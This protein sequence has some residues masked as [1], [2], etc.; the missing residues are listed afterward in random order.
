MSDETKPITTSELAAQIR[1]DTGPLPTAVGPVVAAPMPS[2]EGQNADVLQYIME[3]VRAIAEDLAEHKAETKANFAAMGKKQDAT[4]KDVLEIKTGVNIG[5]WVA[6]GV[7]SV[8][9]ILVG[10]YVSNFEFRAKLF[11]VEEVGKQLSRHFIPT[12]PV[13]KTP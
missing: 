9:A 7:L 2:A 3:G 13:A 8:L 4:E 6:T 5:K 11:I 12:T 1:K 10:L